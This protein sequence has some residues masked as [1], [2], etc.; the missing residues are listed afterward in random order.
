MGVRGGDVAGREAIG[1]LQ[2]PS[3]FRHRYRADKARLRNAE[4]T[5][6]QRSGF[7]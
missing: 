3:G 6:D 5:L 1:A 7:A 2:N 4:S